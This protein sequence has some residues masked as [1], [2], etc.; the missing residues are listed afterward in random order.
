MNPRSGSSVSRVRILLADD[1]QLMREGLRAI[2]AQDPSFRI[3]G[4]AT[5]GRDA[6]RAAAA[7]QPDVILM[8]IAMKDLNG[9]EATREIHAAHPSIA[10]VALSTYSSRI[11]VAEAL[12][13][14]ASAYILKANAYAELRQGISAA[15][16]G[17]VYVCPEL[18]VPRPSALGEDPGEPAVRAGS[19]YSLLGPREREVLQL[20]AEGLSSPEIAERMSRSVSTVDTHR[21]NLMRKLGI[22]SVAGLTKYAIRE[23]LTLVDEV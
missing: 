5:T 8:D 20:V 4:E 7:L 6:V 17:R 23:G 21:R 2:L 15:L 18:R 22:H 9:I 13:A 10:I 12:E 3:V 11:Y 14:G 1:H 16:A 19:V